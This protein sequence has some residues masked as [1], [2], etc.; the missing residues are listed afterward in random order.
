MDT[1]CEQNKYI[2]DY[3]DYLLTV[4]GYSRHTLDSYEYDLIWLFRFLK[5]RNGSAGEIGTTRHRDGS[6]T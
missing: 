3:L 4:K 5:I 1:R 2:R 6:V